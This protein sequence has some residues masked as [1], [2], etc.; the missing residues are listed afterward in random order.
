MFSHTHIHKQGTADVTTVE[1]RKAEFAH[2]YNA[3]TPMKIQTG[4]LHFCHLVWT[5]HPGTTDHLGTTTVHI[6]Q[7]HGNPCWDY[8]T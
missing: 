1:D 6:K 7:A 8:H 2:I 3:V 4:H 5:D